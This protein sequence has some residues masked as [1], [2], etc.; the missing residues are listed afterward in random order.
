M[1]LTR[2]VWSALC[3]R[4]EPNTRRFTA[5]A[6]LI[7]GP[8]GAPSGVVGKWL[9]MFFEKVMGVASGVVRGRVSVVLVLVVVGGCE[10]V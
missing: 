5:V 4:M 1:M 6:G 8:G 3:L 2:K 7:W 9:L 10:G